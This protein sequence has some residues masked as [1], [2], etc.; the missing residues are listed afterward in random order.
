MAVNLNKPRRWKED[1][2]RSVDLYNEWFLDFAPDTY[3][4]ERVKATKHVQD[5]LHRTKH[6][7]N[8]TPDELQSH[9]SILFALRMATA[10]PIARDRLV[11]LPG[12]SNPLVNNREWEHRPPPQM[13]P[14]TL[15]ANPQKIIK[16]IIR[17]VDVDIFPL[18][19]EDRNPTKQEIY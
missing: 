12:I 19:G 3:R 13:K 1:I 14:N 10:P 7:R 16:M 6:L 8:L 17:L 2:A 5:M 18:L 4:K 9:P 15:D 11:G